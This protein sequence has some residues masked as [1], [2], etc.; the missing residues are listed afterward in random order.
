MTTKHNPTP[1]KTDNRF[2]IIGA[3][4]GLVIALPI[5]LTRESRDRHRLHLTEQTSP[6]VLDVCLD[7]SISNRNAL[8]WEVK[9]LN[10]LQDGL[11]PNETWLDISRIDSSLQDLYSDLL[12]DSSETFLANLTAN[13]KPVSK[14][15]NTYLSLYFTE[16]AKRAKDCKGNIVVIVAS[17]AYCEGEGPEGHRKLAE[18]ARVLAK[19]P[20]VKRVFLVGTN[21]A[22]RAMI[23][24][25]LSAI[26]DRVLF[27][28]N[29][30]P[31]ATLIDASFDNAEG[32]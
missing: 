7:T 11:D 29:G 30:F 17:D 4:L 31:N 14:V 22:N 9:G 18:A 19:N 21:P 6:R 10:Q 8:P 12:P 23:S 32:R 25:D 28:E 16:L 24:E 13:L 15:D 20:R 2:A 27:P 26:K 3:V 1:V 5:C